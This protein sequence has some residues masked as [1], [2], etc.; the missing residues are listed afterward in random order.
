M[1]RSKTAFAAALLTVLALL[2]LAVAPVAAGDSKA[3]AKAEQ[4]RIVK[5]WTAERI[6]NAK[7]RDFVKTADGKFVPRAK[8]GG[9]T[10]SSWTGGG[11]VVGRT[12]KVLFTMGG[13]NWVC[14]A[15]AVTDSRT[16]Y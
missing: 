9:G 15:S 8:P 10:G 16:G 13:S 4:Q 5:Y 11:P 2:P 14:S 12:G 6:A 3:A 7:P 1:R